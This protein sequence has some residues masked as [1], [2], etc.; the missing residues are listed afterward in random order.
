MALRKL[1][2]WVYLGFIK[3][4]LKAH[5]SQVKKDVEKELTCQVPVN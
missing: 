5:W 1:M 3:V 4:I 2:K